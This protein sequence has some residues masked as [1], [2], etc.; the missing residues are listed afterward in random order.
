MARINLSIPDRLKSEMDALEGRANWSALATE[1]FER[2]VRKLNRVNIMETTQVAERL[3]ASFEQ[4]GVSLRDKG[5]QTGVE[6]AARTAEYDELAWL[7]DSED[8]AIDLSDW[9][10]SDS[11][12]EE[13]E[14]KKFWERAAGLERLPSADYVWGFVE[15][16]VEMFE[17]V[18][19]Q[20]TK[21]RRQVRPK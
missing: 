8:A 1:S 15:G 18:R 7:S 16:A 4:S 5:H 9:Q 12:F 13:Y 2:E 11:P 3:R 20:V 17:R 14:P 21:K 6:W 10:V 19:D